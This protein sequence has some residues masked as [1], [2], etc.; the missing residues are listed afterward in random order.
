MRRH[1]QRERWDDDGDDRVRVLIECAAPDSPSIVATT[2]ERAGYATRTCPGPGE[3]ACDLDRHGACDLV[4]GADVVV[5]LLPS[6]EGL[7]LAGRIASSRRP[8]AVVAQVRSSSH[9][10]ATGWTDPSAAGGVVAVR[11]PAT[12]RALLAAI[13]TAL[14]ENGGHGGS[15]ATPEPS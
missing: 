9:R 11:A 8:P 15:P 6:E 7:A 4:D 5:N 1:Q 3:V 10:A 13:Q 2:I 12:R 14:A